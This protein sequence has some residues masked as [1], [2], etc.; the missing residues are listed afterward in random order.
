MKHWGLSR[1]RISSTCFPNRGNSHRGFACQLFRC[2]PFYLVVFVMFCVVC[3][4]WK[5]FFP[6]HSGF[7]GSVFIYFLFFFVSGNCYVSWLVCVA[8]CD[9]RSHFLYF[10]KN[11]SLGLSWVFYIVV[12]RVI[13]AHSYPCLIFCNPGQNNIENPWQP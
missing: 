8:I 7:C 9:S 3:M 1:Y 13:D 2:P 6:I 4:G 12:P 5:C 11:I 10:L